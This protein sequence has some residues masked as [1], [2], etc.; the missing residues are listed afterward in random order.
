MFEQLERLIIDVLLW[1]VS[2]EDINAFLAESPHNTAILIGGLIAVSGALLGTFLLL[3]RM[4]LITD[5][6]SHTVLLGIVV[7]FMVMTRL[8]DMEFSIASPL[9]I[10]GSA[11]AGVGTVL[12]TEWLF[13]SGLVK[14]D[15][16]LGLA[17]P[18]LFAIAVILISR[19][20]D[21][22]HL[23][24]DAVYVGDIGFA[25][26]NTNSHCL[27]NCSDITIL[28]DDPRA[29]VVREC[30]NCASE[31]LYP[32]DPAAVFA[33]VCGNCGTYSPAE[34]VRAESQGIT[35]FAEN[36]PRPTFVY[37][38]ESLT[39]MGVITLLNLLFVVLFYKELQ[40]TAFDTALAKTLG[41]RPAALTYA[42]L[43]LVSITAVGA[44]DA[45]GAIL[46]VAFFIIP[47]AIAY[48]LTDRLY[49]M[50]I[51]APIA[52]VIAIY[53]GMDLAR[54]D[55]LGVLQVSDVLNV[56]D[57]TIGLNGYTEWNVSISASMVMML[58]FVFVVA[59]I[60]SPR[61]GVLATFIRRISQR[62]RFADQL[63]LGHLY[64]HQHTAEMDDEC[65]LTTLPEHLNWSSQ[66]VNRVVQGLRFR[67]LVEVHEGRVTLTDS[68]QQ[69]LQQFRQRLITK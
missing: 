33:E 10:I 3:R 13:Q 28:P 32:R 46:V 66:Q 44:F 60:A 58:F 29:N 12:L 20:A 61:Y 68:G 34:A 48:L 45:V 50:L 22:V 42:L 7:S 49:Q 23:D 1:V 11:L 52:G 9:L 37:W 16:A 39:V 56:I 5:A 38:P 64:N 65:G 57:D 26:S 25:S 69:Q 21:D 35:V 2:A 36:D 63:L 8:L 19:Y 30:T 53:T 6:I 43:V 55:F 54:G 15:A 51:I 59:W 27:M 4:A 24:V 41:F 14:A 31:N 62:R 47:P 67:Q 18:F 17:F 40:L